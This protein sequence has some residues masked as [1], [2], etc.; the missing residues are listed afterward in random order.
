MVIGYHTSDVIEGLSEL[1]NLK[2]E[3]DNAELENTNEMIH[4]FKV[5]DKRIV[6]FIRSKDYK[7]YFFNSM[8]YSDIV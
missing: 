1:P 7:I 4:Q 3:L 2:F 5:P 8:I 6:L